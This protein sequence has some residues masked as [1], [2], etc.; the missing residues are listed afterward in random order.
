MPKYRVIAEV[1]DGKGGKVG[2]KKADRGGLQNLPCKC[3][4]TRQRKANGSLVCTG[5]GSRGVETPL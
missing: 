3:G 2:V 4:G 1:A 5:C